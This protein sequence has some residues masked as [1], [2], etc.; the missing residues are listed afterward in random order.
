MTEGILLRREDSRAADVVV[1]A[2]VHVFVV[3]GVAAVFVGIGDD[4][5][6]GDEEGFNAPSVICLMVT[7][8]RP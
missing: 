2:H 3:T 5:L 8:L 1:E 4:I 6:L 7:R